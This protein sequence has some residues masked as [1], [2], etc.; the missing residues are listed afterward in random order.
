MRP[1]GKGGSL[2]YM[3]HSMR[4]LYLPGPKTDFQENMFPGPDEKTRVLK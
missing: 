2:T 3:I 1:H 4:S